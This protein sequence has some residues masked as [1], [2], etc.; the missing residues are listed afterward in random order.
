MSNTLIICYDTLKKLNNHFM[1]IHKVY[2]D[3]F[4]LAQLKFISKQFQNLYMKSS[5]CLNF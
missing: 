3:E 5:R 1:T 2:I 4:Y